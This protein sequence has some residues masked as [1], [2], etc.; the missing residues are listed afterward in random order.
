MSTLVQ[1]EPIKSGPGTSVP[2]EHVDREQDVLPTRRTLRTT[3]G[4]ARAASALFA[5]DATIA[6]RD[7]DGL[8]SCVVVKG[9]RRLARP[10]GDDLIVL[11][12]WDL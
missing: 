10:D 3:V 6:G 12:E 2:I 11:V 5:H 1:C 7:H 9:V 8:R 4:A